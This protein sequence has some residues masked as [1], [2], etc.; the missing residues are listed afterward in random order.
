MFF[1]LSHSKN[2][3]QFL[4][5]KLYKFSKMKQIQLLLV[6]TVF[7]MSL[8]SSCQKEGPAGPA[9]PAGQQGPPGAAGVAGAQGPQGIAGN[10]NVTQYTYGNQ[11]LVTSFRTLQVTTTVDTFNRSAWFVY[12]YYQ[13][14]DRWYSLPGFGFGASTNYRVSMG[15]SGNK[16]SIFID[17]TGPGE[18]YAQAKVIRIYANS[19]GPGGR[20]YQPTIDYTDYEAVRSYYKLP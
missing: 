14:L 13:P 9:G 7:A 4:H 6:A 3:G 16:V 11:D 1:P 15:Y 17:K 10:A 20:V 2:S 19:V 5:S 12:L 18:V 8:L